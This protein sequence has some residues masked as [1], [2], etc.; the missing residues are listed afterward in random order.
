M[1]FKRLNKT[2]FSHLIAGAVL[3]A[4]V[5]IPSALAADNPAVDRQKVMSHVG[6]AT[7][8]GAAMARG[9]V[10]FDAVQAQLIMRTMNGVA[11]GY[12]YLFPEGSETG[13]KTEASP[14]IWSDRAG[15]NAAVKKF[16]DDTSVLPTDLDGFRAAFQQVTANC[17]TCHRAYRVKN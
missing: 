17:G 15:F 6:A 5:A 10:P 16:I 2:P 7:G 9:Q 12:G 14:A 4:V 3:S 1:T 8:A 13:A 11:L